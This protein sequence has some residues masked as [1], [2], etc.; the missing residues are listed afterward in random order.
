MGRAAGGWRWKV[1]E[2]VL[3][4]GRRAGSARLGLLPSW[5]ACSLRPPSLVWA[6]AQLWLDGGTSRRSRPPVRSLALAALTLAG[7]C[8]RFHLPTTPSR[9]RS[10]SLHPLPAAL[11]FSAH[12]PHRPPHV[13]EPARLPAA[14]GLPPA[15]AAALRPSHRLPGPAAAAAPG[16]SP[17]LG[18]P[19]VVRV[20][21]RPTAA[22]IPVRV[23]GPLSSGHGLGRWPPPPG[24]GLPWRWRRLDAP[25]DWLGRR[26][27]RRTRLSAHGFPGPSATDDAVLVYADEHCL[28]E[29]C[30]YLISVPLASLSPSRGRSRGP[31]TPPFA[32]LLAL[33]LLTAPFLL[34]SKKADSDPLF[35]PCSP[36][37]L[38]ALSPSSSPTSP[39]ATCRLR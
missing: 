22:D 15:A 17:P 27:R 38:V 26:W 14:G 25:S 1:C 6:L 29:S 34:L 39:L 8:P 31:R 35:L 24:N 12:D 4:K 28:C 16:P 9:A 21:Q 23:D 13:L 37:G 7:A 33:R 32:L 36:T 5:R 19:A 20:P 18:W 2:R 3:E 10:P 11:L 30:F